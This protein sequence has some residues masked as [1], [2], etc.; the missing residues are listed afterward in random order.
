MSEDKY[1]SCRNSITGNVSLALKQLNHCLI[2]RLQDG[3]S[4]IPAGVLTRYL[5]ILSKNFES[6]L[7]AF[8]VG[9]D[10]SVVASRPLYGGFSASSTLNFKWLTL[11]LQLQ[12]RRLFVEASRLLCQAFRFRQHILSKWLA[13]GSFR[14]CRLAATPASGEGKYVPF[15]L[16]CEGHG[17]TFF[18]LSPSHSSYRGPE[19][20]EPLV[21]VR[22]RPAGRGRS[23][24]CPPAPGLRNRARTPAGRPPRPR[25]P[26]SPHAL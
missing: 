22:P 24:A 2:K 20:A 16:V 4:S 6:G 19:L 18:T 23:C 21:P 11:L 7:S 14:G 1:F 13:S 25:R 9:R 26:P 15:H 10:V 5:R 3:Q 12:A 8:F 17:R